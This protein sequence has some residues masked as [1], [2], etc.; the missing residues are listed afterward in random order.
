VDDRSETPDA[1]LDGG[2]LRWLARQMLDDARARLVD[3]GAD[4]DQPVQLAD[5]FVDLPLEG[6]PPTL[7]LQTFLGPRPAKDG[8]TRWLLVG[9]AGSGKTTL[10]TML[11]QVLRRPFVLAQRAQWAERNA[12]HLE[13]V[14]AALGKVEAVQEDFAARWL[15]IRVDLPTLAGFIAAT[16]SA[17]AVERL[18]SFHIAEAAEGDGGTAADAVQELLAR[19]D[20]FWIFDGLDEVPSTAQRD[21][22]VAAVREVRSRATMAGSW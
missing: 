9:G 15:P 18:L 4:L 14:C 16:G 13:R 7:A 2:V 10:S 12:P 22:L 1:P 20:L 6:P 11:A 19:R 8:N 21:A 3:V 5:V 17:R